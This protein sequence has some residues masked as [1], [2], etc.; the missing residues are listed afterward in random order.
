M[1]D[2]RKLERTKHPGIY[3][4][5]SRFVVI[6]RHRGRQHKRSFRTLSEARRFKGQTDA[7]G[8]AP[9]SRETLVSYAERWLA[10]YTGRTGK[11]LSARTRDSYRD[12]VERIIVP[13]LRAK[14]PSL[15]LDEAAPTDVRAYIAHLTAQGYAPATVRRYHAP[16]RAMLATAYE[17]GLTPRNPAS[18]VRVIVPGERDRKPKRMT[19]DQTRALLAAMPADHADLAYLMAATGL[20][21]GEALGLTWADF[22]RN[23]GGRP[24]LTVCRS[25]TAAGERSVP[26]TPE[27]V[28]RLTARRSEVAHECD[29]DPIFASVFG[30]PIDAH[31]WRRRVFR[32]AAEAAGV[33]WATPHMLR[34]GMASLIA[35]QGYS[36][37][38]IAAHLGH[39]DGGVLALRTYVHAD[40]IDSLE[41]VD[42]ALGA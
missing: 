42:E 41:F 23:D 22:R 14:A 15:R 10:V 5:G 13:Y 20:R 30:T 24:V 31:N 18:E 2:D 9:T 12:A 1:A 17:D 35:Q 36:P 29:D 32:P 6:W 4:K 16:L 25:K 21:I 40:P 28:R 27:T 26:L 38:H 7:G 34:H 19:A 33:P 37:A 8:A 39:A 3:R 11:G